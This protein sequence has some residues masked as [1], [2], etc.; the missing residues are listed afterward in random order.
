MAQLSA[1]DHLALVNVSMPI[2]CMSHDPTLLSYR[3]KSVNLMVPATR[4]QQNARMFRL[5]LASRVGCDV[6]TF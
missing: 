5:A 1:V 4:L 6:S 3:P 2:A